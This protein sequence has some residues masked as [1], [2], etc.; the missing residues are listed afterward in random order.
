MAKME[1]IENFS[2]S[3]ASKKTKR[4]VK[5]NDVSMARRTFLLTNTTSALSDALLSCCYL[6]HEACASRGKEI[7]IAPVVTIPHSFRGIRNGS[8]GLRL[9]AITG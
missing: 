7:S 5:G 1:V 6:S 2:L 8:E 3:L 4:K 9:L